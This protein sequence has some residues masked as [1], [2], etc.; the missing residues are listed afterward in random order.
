MKKNPSKQTKST[1]TLEHVHFN[2]ESEIQYEG[3]RLSGAYSDEKS[4]SF[5][6]SGFTG[7]TC[8]APNQGGYRIGIV[9]LLQF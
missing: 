3:P 6:V 7:P 5:W 4:L 9:I 8:F 2:S 1:N